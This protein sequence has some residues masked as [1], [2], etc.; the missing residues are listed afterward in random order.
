MEIGAVRV[1]PPWILACHLHERCFTPSFAQLQLRRLNR[2][3]LVA[4]KLSAIGICIDEYIL[5]E[6]TKR[7][8]AAW[9]QRLGKDIQDLD[10]LLGTGIWI[11]PMWEPQFEAVSDRIIPAWRS[12]VEAVSHL[13][14]RPQ[15]MSLA[16]FHELERI[17]LD[18]L[19]KRIDGPLAVVIPPR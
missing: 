1:L 9:S 17:V 5:A 11:D 8:P 7:D 19:W 10:L 15:G 14:Q 13:R 12:T 6:K 4:S 18:V 16:D 3:G 2:L